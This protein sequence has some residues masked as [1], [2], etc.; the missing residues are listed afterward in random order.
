MAVTIANVLAGQNT[1]VATVIASADADVTA[2]IPH[3]LLAT[4]KLFGFCL[5]LSQALTAQSAWSCAV[6]GATNMVGTKLATTG[7][8]NAAIQAL[9]WCMTPHSLI[10]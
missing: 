9:F 6:P 1:F 5:V 8:G 10:S 7:S 2:T 4:P 3:G